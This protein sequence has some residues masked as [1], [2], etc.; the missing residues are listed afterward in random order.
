MN[1]YLLSVIG[2]I[3]DAVSD[4]SSMLSD[5]PARIRTLWVTFEQ[6]T[7][8]FERIHQ[9]LAERVCGGIDPVELSEVECAQRAAQ[10]IDEMLADIPKREAERRHEAARNEIRDHQLVAAQSQL[11]QVCELL[12]SDIDAASIDPADMD[13]VE[14][15]QAA[16]RT[17]R[18]LRSLM[19][20]TLEVRA[21][22]P[23]PIGYTAVC[24]G[25]VL[26]IEKDFEEARSTAEKL[27]SDHHEPVALCALKPMLYGRIE[28]RAVWS[29]Q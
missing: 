20:P 9:I 11:D 2:D 14:M 1:D 16:Q 23:A 6:Q 26:V 25:R 15:A 4:H 3:R 24:E 22:E 13:A 28:R 12:C 18:D 5:L 27:L 10:M 19:P 17:I 8:D 21:D 7:D 29:G